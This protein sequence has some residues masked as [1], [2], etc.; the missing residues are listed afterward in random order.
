M[1][2]NLPTIGFSEEWE[3]FFE[4]HPLWLEKFKLLHST[5][6][7]VFIR[8]ISPEGPADRVVFLLGRLCV[9]DLSEVFILSGNGHGFGAL[10]LG[11]WGRTKLSNR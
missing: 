8:P 9:K 1:D 2:S 7:R 3:A 10:K 6:E 11:N 5:I 4:R